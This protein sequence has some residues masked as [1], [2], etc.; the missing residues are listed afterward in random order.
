M[1]DGLACFQMSKITALPEMD[2]GGPLP[3]ASVAGEEAG[4]L[5]FWHPRQ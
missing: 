4:S 5:G 3:G 1:D 2:Q